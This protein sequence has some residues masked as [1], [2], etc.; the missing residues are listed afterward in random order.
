MTSATSR[1]A[2]SG[3]YHPRRLADTDELYLED[4]DPA[5]LDEPATVS[6]IRWA[7]RTPSRGDV[8]PLGDG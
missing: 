6:R 7:L 5:A 8:P 2:T 1:P 3:R 4:P